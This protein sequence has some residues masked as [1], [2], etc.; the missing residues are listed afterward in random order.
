MLVGKVQLVARALV[1]L[2]LVA[3]L[4]APPPVRHAL[5]GFCVSLSKMPGVEL[6]RPDI[7][8]PV[9]GSSRSQAR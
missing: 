7:S 3:A 9:A 6:L 8:A 2:L 1:A 5:A 4:V